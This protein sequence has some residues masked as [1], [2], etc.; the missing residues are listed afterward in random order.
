M[1]NVFLF[2]HIS[3]E[4]KNFIFIFFEGHQHESGADR[5]QEVEPAGELDSP[6]TCQFFRQSELIRFRWKRN[7]GL[8][9]FGKILNILFQFLF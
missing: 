7:H 5:C 3:I 8:D 9:L 6:E 1:K 4:N 2:L